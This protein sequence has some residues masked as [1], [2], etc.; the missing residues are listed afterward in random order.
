MKS[1]EP[2]RLSKFALM[3]AGARHDQSSEAKQAK[4]L[5]LFRSRDGNVFA[6]VYESAI[7][8]TWPVKSR[9]FSHL[10]AR[11]YFEVENKIATP[12]QAIINQIEAQAQVHTPEREV[13]HRVGKFGD[14]LYLDLADESWSAVEIDALGLMRMM[15]GLLSVKS[16]GRVLYSRYRHLAMRCLTKSAR[17][18][19]TDSSESGGLRSRLRRY[20]STRRSTTPAV[21]DLRYKRGGLRLRENGGFGR[22]SYFIEPAA[23]A[24]QTLANAKWRG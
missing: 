5:E 15:T 19:K 13:S 23:V 14:R 21:V 24:Y 7:R 2:H 3:I 11:R 22:L 17:G 6:D 18:L 1:D 8:K 16:P 9:Q 4:K 10:L 12:S 20:R